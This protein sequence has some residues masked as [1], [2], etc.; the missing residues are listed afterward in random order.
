MILYTDK[1]KLQIVIA[2]SQNKNTLCILIFLYNMYQSLIMACS[3][4]RNL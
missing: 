4:G 2:S 1:T 3:K